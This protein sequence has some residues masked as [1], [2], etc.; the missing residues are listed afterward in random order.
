MEEEEEE[1]E[2]EEGGWGW[3]RGLVLK[4]DQ[5]RPQPDKEGDDGHGHGHTRGYEHDAHDFV[6]GSPALVARQQTRTFQLD[7]KAETYS[8]LRAVDGQVS[9]MHIVAD[10][11]GGR[12]EL[13]GRNEVL[14]ANVRQQG[15]GGK[16]HHE[17]K[18]KSHLVVNSRC[19]KDEN[20]VR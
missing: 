2:E 12:G 15:E 13:V 6:A 11:A 8:E 16:Q 20:K 3:D 5:C 4:D 1:E 17:R 7:T 10:A 9:Q 14:C 18:V 19:Y